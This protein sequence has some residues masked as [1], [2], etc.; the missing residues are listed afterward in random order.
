MRFR[1]LGVR[2]WS[3]W[4]WVVVSV[5]ELVWCWGPPW[6]LMW[7]GL[8]DEN[9]DDDD[10]EEDREDDE[11][12]REPGEERKEAGAAG[13]PCDVVVSQRTLAVAGSGGV[14]SFDLRRWQ[15][16]FQV[17]GP[18]VFRDQKGIVWVKF[19][20]FYLHFHNWGKVPAHDEDHTPARSSGSTRVESDMPATIKFL[21]TAFLKA[22]FLLRRCSYPIPQGPPYQPIKPTAVS[23]PSCT[24]TTSSHSS[25]S[26]SN[27][28]PS[29]ACTT[30]PTPH[31]HTLI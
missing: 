13:V 29:L 14:C 8:G 26:E 16:A 5:E 24:L 18:R 19:Q 12:M 1:P 7:G 17:K 27:T 9:D 21:S 31:S 15:R 10:D 25:G 2:W 3:W 22:P 23:L 28:I 4:S 20:L 6:L 30:N 11:V